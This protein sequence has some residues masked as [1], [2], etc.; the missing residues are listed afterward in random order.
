MTYEQ[1]RAYQKELKS[2]GKT[3]STSKEYGKVEN[4]IKTLKPENYGKETVSDAYKQ[5]SSGVKYT[6]GWTEKNL[7]NIEKYT[8]TKPQLISPSSVTSPDNL[9]S[10]LNN[11]QDSV[12][13]SAGSPELRESI[14]AQLEPDMEK[15]EPL[16]RV[17]EYETMRQNMGVADLETTLTDLKAQLEQE[18][19]TTRARRFDAEGK[20]VAMGV[21]AGRVS[22]IERQQNERVDALGRQINVIND[23]LTTAYN[24]ISTY[25]NFMSLDYQDAVN[26]YNTEFS[27]NLQ[28]YNL[29]DE[30]MDEQMANARANLQVYQN[31]ILSGNINY[32]SLPT[33]QKAFISKL[34]VQAGLPVGFT[35]TLKPDEKVLYS[36]TRTADGVKYLD[37]I[38]QGSNGQPITNTITLGSTGEEGGGGGGS[39]TTAKRGDIATA[40]GV[41]KATPSANPTDTG[42]KYL[43]ANEISS[44]MQQLVEKFGD[45]EYAATVF[46][47]ATEEYGYNEWKE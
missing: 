29:I 17:E 39:T 3:A 42:D 21:I 44:I 11:Y 9:S 37:T 14:A 19:A 46:E 26:A 22:E 33:S 5:L 41:I 15:P 23:Q 27:R 7:G 30:E 10:Y 18:Y 40:I 2:Q 38:T 45:R 6:G 16:N 1:A 47:K 8:G 35:G 4:Y 20:P 12:Y 28:I 13:G 34:E 31:A 32:A 24:V 36:G 25:M 43:S